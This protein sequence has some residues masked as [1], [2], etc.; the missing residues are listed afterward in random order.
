MESNIMKY[1]KQ[2]KQFYEIYDAW[3]AYYEDLL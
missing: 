2:G 3:K 1:K